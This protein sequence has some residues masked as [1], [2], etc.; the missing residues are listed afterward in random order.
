M[1]G[2]SARGSEGDIAIIGMAGLYPQADDVD[3]FWDNILTK[4]DAITTSSDAWL[5][6]GDLL[7]PDS[8]DPMKIYTRKGGFLGD[9]SRFNP[10]QFGTMPMSIAGAQPDQFLALKIA[11][12]ALIDAGYAP[13]K[14]DG[15]ATGVILGHSVHAHRGNTNGIQ[16]VWFHSQTRSLL[17]TLFPDLPAARLDAAMA[18]MQDK[19][20]KLT[21]EAIPGL[22]PNVLTGRIANRLD[23]MGPNY[24]IDAACSSSIIAVDLA[25]GELLAGKADMMLA[26]GINTTTSPLVYGVF[27]SVDALSR[28]GRI[29][30]FDKGANGTATAQRPASFV[31]STPPLPWSSVA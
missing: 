27:C 21:P 16:Q 15:T 6:N 1:S 25:I 4:K 24:I 13:G 3:V 23:L 31:A 9:L 2:Q 28:D 22:V 7:D 26:G 19:L 5:G 20:P 30:P 17:Q 18:L 12:D 29:R 14:F 11:H 10:A 8:D